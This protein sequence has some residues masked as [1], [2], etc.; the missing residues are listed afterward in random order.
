QTPNANYAWTVVIDGRVYDVESHLLTT[1]S[2]ETLVHLELGE[3]FDADTP[4][5]QIILG[6]YNTNATPYSF[7]FFANLTQKN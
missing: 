4:F 5:D 1:S 7:D 2:A 3:D 6:I